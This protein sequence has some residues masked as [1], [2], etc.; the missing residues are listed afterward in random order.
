[1]N[2]VIYLFLFVIRSHSF[3][4]QNQRCHYYAWSPRIGFNPSRS[5]HHLLEIDPPKNIASLIDGEFD[6][7]NQGSET[8]FQWCVLL[9]YSFESNRYDPRIKE[10]DL[11]SP[12]LGIESKFILS[13]HPLE[14]WVDETDKAEKKKEPNPLDKENTGMD[15]STMTPPSVKEVWT[16]VGK[17][18]KTPST[19]QP[20]VTISLS[21]N[22]T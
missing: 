1:M 6:F 7:H 15:G 20:M 18:E 13:S 22:P 21:R 2:N 8:S 5:L 11:D 14:S 19:P 16:I 10:K 9:G 3:W 4:L 17:K 12:N